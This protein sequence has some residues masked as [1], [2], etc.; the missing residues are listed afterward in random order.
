VLAIGASPLMLGWAT[1]VLKDA[2]MAAC[3][4]AATGI[5]AHYRLRGAALPWPA[6]A[7]ILVLIVYAA[8][9]R[10][11]AAFACAPLALALADWGGVRGR[12]AR[13]ALTLG[14]TAAILLLSPAINQRLLGAE[15]NHAER[16]LP[17][18]D[19]AGIAHFAHA[20]TMPG[21]P[22]GD[23]QR[24][25][26]AHCYSPFFWNPYGEPEQ[27]GFVGDRLAFGPGAGRGLTQAWA[28]TIAAHPLAYATHR[29]LHL[30]ANLR[31]WT[32]VAERD[33]IPPVDS[34]PNG[35][36]LGAHASP[37]T[38][39]LITAARWQVASPLGW[40]VTWLVASLILLWAS[41]RR[42]DAQARLGRALA[43]S[44]ACMS[45]SFAIVSIAS[46]LR[47]HL[48]SMLAAALA[49]LLLID[50]RA[51]DPRR[52]RIGAALMIALAV[53]G[54]GARLGLAAPVYIP[55]PVHVPPPPGARS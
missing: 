35:Y 5:F 11:N 31:L 14:A 29:L 10:G 39:A 18:Y 34:E 49:A 46:D 52:A 17:T 13:A 25:E 2:Q 19:L 42:D 12:T 6:V 48:W 24:A 50:G 55:L 41:N 21:L 37:A 54:F 26:A 27:C 28:W 23:W 40:P 45:G 20:A 51:L 43:L 4:V 1:V 3:L 44:A 53:V 47:Y 36:G 16:A 9:V 33:A 30:N 22:A 7:A 38:R 15:A 32:D 8:L